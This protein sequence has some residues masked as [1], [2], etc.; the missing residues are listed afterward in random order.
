MYKLNLKI[1]LRNLRKNLLVTLISIGGLAIA[2]SA[3]ILLLLYVNYET[4]YDKENPEYQNIYLVGRNLKDQKS[5][6]TPPALSRLIREKCPSVV[7]TG[8]LKPTRFEFPIISDHNRVYTSN[9]LTADY[10]AALIL[11]LQPES[12]LTKPVGAEERLFYLQ[13]ESMQVLFPDKK[14]NKEELVL[15][16][17]KSAGQTATIKGAIIPRKHSTIQFDALVVT[18]EMGIDEGFEQADYFTYIQVKPGTDIENLRIQISRLLK[19]GMGKEGIIEEGMDPAQLNTGTDMIYLDPLANLHLR[20][21]AGNNANYKVVMVILVLGF[22]I[23]LIACINFTN[24]SIAQANKRAKEVGVKKVLGANRHTLTLQFITEIVIQCTIAAVLSLILVELFLPAF[25]QLFQVPLSVSQPGSHLLIFLPAML[26]GVILIAGIYPAFVLSGYKPALVLKGNFQTSIQS[27]WLR[28]GLLVFQFSIAVIFITGL[29]IV[30]AQL[31]YMHT[32]DT[33]FNPDQVVYIKNQSYF[34]KPAVFSQVRDKIMKIEGIKAVTVSSIIPDG[35]KPASGAY[36]SNGVTSVI[37]YIDVDFDYFQALD[38]RLKEG[39]FFS[40]Q[41]RTDTATAAVLNESAVARYGLQQPVGKIIK[42]CQTTY[43]IIGIIKDF[44]SQGFEHAV[45]P[46][47]Y[48]MKNP[49]GNARTNIMIKINQDHMAAALATIKSQWND[50]NTY[51]GEDFRYEFLDDLYGK[52][53]RQQEL[54]QSVFLG[55]SFITIGIALIGLF[56][57][58]KF[59]TA[60]RTK[61]IAVRKILGA[62]NLDILKLLNSTF[63]KMA[64]LANLLALPFAWFLAE[65]WLMNFAYRIDLSPGPFLVTTVLTII[66]TLTTVSLQVGKAVRKTPVEALKYE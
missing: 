51:D 50:I 63:V 17:S 7:L 1:A 36:T 14:D 58:A 16:G 24:L 44:K 20:P 25:N 39:R 31:K 8:K 54:L 35:S 6:Y 57:L 55:S 28:K 48:A 30:S 49:C 21:A 3:F 61:E 43:K 41:F 2:L 60:S 18:K 32:A 59:M 53:F 13:K 26:L 4:G 38:I 23:L 66:L 22:L 27:M 40:E 5:A 33:G 62:N 42:G 47:I 29:F 19:E 12:G 37:D 34:N 11:G 52:M 56:A 65:K 46:T 15:F 10:E 64:L 9:S 45:Q